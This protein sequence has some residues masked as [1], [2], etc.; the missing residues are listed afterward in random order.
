M[1]ISF[2]PTECDHAKPSQIYPQTK[3][4]SGECFVDDKWGECDLIS[5]LSY[6]GRQYEVCLSVNFM[7]VRILSSNFTP[8]FS[9]SDIIF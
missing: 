9:A 4:V 5:L 7:Y 1:V 3:E 6:F 2:G 8:P